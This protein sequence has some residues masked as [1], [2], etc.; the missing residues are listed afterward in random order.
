MQHFAAPT[1]GFF[2]QIRQRYNGVHQTHIQRLFRVVL[3]A[4]EPDFTRFFLSNDASHV[5]SAPAAVE[6][7]DFRA[8]LTEDGII[9]RD[10]QVA[11]HVQDVTATDGVASHHRDN[12][13]WTG[14]DL[15]LEVQHV[16]VMYAG[17]IFIAAVITTYFLVTTGAERF[18]ACTSQN[19]HADVVV[20]TRIRQ[21]LDH[22]FYRQ[23]TEGIAHLRTINGDF[24]DTV[25]GFFITNVLKTFGAVVPFNRC[26]KHCFIR[27]N[28]IVSFSQKRKICA[29]LAITPAGFSRCALCPARGMTWQSAASSAARARNLLSRSPHK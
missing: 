2:F 25:G 17:I 15:T 14:T 23:R 22:L 16:Q 12:R 3:T 21:R 27:I 11:H 7:T 18:I 5:G 8:S 13:F 10:S 28:H 6:G 9:S 20:I 1:D 29:R 24:C 4:Q 26:V 19:D